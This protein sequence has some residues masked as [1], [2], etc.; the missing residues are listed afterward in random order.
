MKI[1][2]LKDDL[3]SV[4]RADDNDNQE[5]ADFVEQ[6]L[7]EHE[8]KQ[9]P[10][11][12]DM[13]KNI[14]NLNAFKPDMVFNLVESVCGQGKLAVFAPQLL[15][16]LQ[17]PFTGNKSFAHFISADKDLAKDLLL[18]NNLPTPTDEFVKGY[19]YILKAKT[20]HASIGLDESCIITP[21]SA[22]ELKSALH[23]KEKSTKMEW[24]AEQ[25]IDGREFN[26]G[27]LGDEVLP[28][29]EMCFSNDFKGHK[30]L[31]YEAKWNE[32]TSAYQ[33]SRRTF[34]IDSDT[35][36]KLKRLSLLCRGALGLK[37]YSRIDF[38][39]DSAQNLYIIDVNTNPCIAPESGFIA[40][41]HKAGL[42][43]K[44]IIERIMENAFLS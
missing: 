31:T 43:A 23:N 34:D 42:S 1:A 44:K 9:F 7:S 40:M 13:K 6:L 26:V 10:F 11:S 33:K 30:I 38:R 25:Y 8:V 27:L 35:I 32:D 24:I 17:I 2:I 39:M 18:Q 37:G 41:G 14:K 29:A 36:E 22:E 4:I 20:E 16:T 28:P 5:Q 15:E 19:T 12:P 3:T 21:L